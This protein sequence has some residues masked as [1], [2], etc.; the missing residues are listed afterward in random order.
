MSVSLCQ[1]SDEQEIT[2][3]DPCLF[4]LNA[5]DPAPPGEMK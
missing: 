4:L 5:F 3:E 1:V 2:K